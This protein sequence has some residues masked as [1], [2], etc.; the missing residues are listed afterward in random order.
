MYT[1]HNTTTACLRKLTAAGMTE[2][3]P[4]RFKLREPASVRREKQHKFNKQGMLGVPQWIAPY[5]RLVSDTG[6]KVG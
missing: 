6:E 2:F 5:I 1:A 3:R 4:V